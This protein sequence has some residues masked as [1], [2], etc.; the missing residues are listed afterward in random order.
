MHDA[1]EYDVVVAAGEQIT[2]GLLAIEVERR[3][4]P[5]RSWMGWQVPIHTSAMHGSA[6]I[7]DIDTALMNERLRTGAGGR[8]GRLSGHRARQPHLDAR[9]RRLGHLSGGAGRGAQGRPLRHLYRRG[10]R[11]HGRSP[12]GVEGAAARPDHLR[13]NARA[14]LAGRQGAAN[15]LGRDG[16]GASCAAA[17]AIDLRSRQRRHH[18]LRRG[19]HRGKEPGHRHRLL[20]RRGQDHPVPRAR[21]ARHRGRRSSVRWP[22]PA[23]T[24][25]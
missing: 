1:R 18:S 15:A 9:P 12:H 4:I 19:R 5:A 20:A 14:R 2:A 11:L 16:D 13:G 22:T 25:T 23:S 10:R 6:R 17:R 21:S 3:G 7:V 8:G 24:S